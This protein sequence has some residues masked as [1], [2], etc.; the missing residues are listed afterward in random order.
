MN[1]IKCITETCEML[2]IDEPA[3][4]VDLD[5]F[6]K[7]L[8]I[9][10][11]SNT[12]LAIYSS[13]D[14]TIYFRNTK[15]L[16]EFTDRDFLFSIMHELRHIW[17]IEYYEDIYFKNY[18]RSSELGIEDYNNQLAEIDANAF[19][20]LACIHYLDLLPQFNGLSEKTKNKIYKR[21]E[22]ISENDLV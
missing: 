2:N 1:I 22:Y 21:M 18:K 10:E 6:D 8:K 19:A 5:K 4:V 3:I 14:R 11:M 20:C 7:L 15:S 12:C 13:E 17:Q 9:Q 16:E